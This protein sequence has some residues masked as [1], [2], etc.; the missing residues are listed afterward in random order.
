MP[1]SST[2]SLKIAAA[3]VWYIGGIILA[4]K[5]SKLFLEATKINPN[6]NWS[7]LAIIFGILIG[8]IKAKYIF[9]KSCR[10]NLT[11]IDLLNKPKV[12]QFY[13]PIFFIFLFAMIALGATLSKMAHSNYTFLISVAILDFSLATALLVSSYTFWEQKAFK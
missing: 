8:L 7:W 3:I 13:R 11:R 4:I 10:K 1:V 12:W 9:M 2:R 6:Q 5:G